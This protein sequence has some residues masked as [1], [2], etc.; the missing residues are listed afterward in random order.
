MEKIGIITQT[1]TRTPN[2]SGIIFRKSKE[3]PLLEYHLSRLKQTGFETAISTSINAEDDELAEYAREKGIPFLRSAA[4]DALGRFHAT[5]KAMGYDI[6]VR[7]SPTCP[8]IDPH[9]IRNA[10][11]KYLRFSNP[12]LYIS[13]TV[14]PSFAEGFGFEIFSFLLLDEAFKHAKDLRDRQEVTP[15]IFRNTSGLNECYHIRQGED[16][17][18]LRVSVDRPHDV[19]H[20]CRLI[21]DYNAGELDYHSIE[22]LLLGDPKLAMLTT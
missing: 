11:E 18:R 12:R 2:A 5:A 4:E 1:Y 8:L 22:Q 14:H 15:Y 19:E 20:V 16:N 17:S 6:L 13:N 9:L 21:E 10:I 3:R 7:V